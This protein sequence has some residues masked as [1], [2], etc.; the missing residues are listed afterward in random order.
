LSKNNQIMKKLLVIALLAIAFQSKSQVI[1]TTKH[2]GIA[3]CPINPVMAKYSDTIPCTYLGVRSIFD[4]L[5]TTCTLYWALVDS[6][7]AT[8]ID[9]NATIGGAD[10]QGWNGSNTYP[11]Y[12]T[13]QQIN[14]TFVTPTTK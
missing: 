5:K 1:D 6:T 9:G 8:H 3:V 14:V 10:Y 11:F 7:G 12:F 13:G 4:N 2:F